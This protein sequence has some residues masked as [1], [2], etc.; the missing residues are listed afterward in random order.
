MK[1]HPFSMIEI[2]LALGVV[3]IGICS[4][5][6]LFP[7]GANANR[8]AQ[9]ET[10]NAQ[11]A[12]HILH[13][14]KCAITFKKDY[15]SKFV[16]DL[17][18]NSAP[19]AEDALPELSAADVASI[20]DSVLEKVSNPDAWTNNSSESILSALGAAG[21]GNK[22]PIFAYGNTATNTFLIVNHHNDDQQI[23]YNELMDHPEQIDFRAIAILW[24]SK[25][26][27]GGT[28]LPYSYG[29]TLNV[30]I[31]WPAEVPSSAQQSALYT[32]D[33]FNNN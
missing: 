11:M 12:D 14:A 17:S 20:P 25:I 18:S 31:F 2:I 15:W 6:V 23:N 10:F 26:N 24:K 30:K 3:A 8:D 7:I 5:M 21:L 16:W 29:V 27:V 33:V 19:S 32:M 28:E 9:A 1:K 13:Y 4:I 22:H